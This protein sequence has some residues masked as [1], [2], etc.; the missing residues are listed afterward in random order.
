MTPRRWMVVLLLF[1]ALMLGWRL[2]QVAS[3]ASACRVV[4]CR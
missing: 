3:M 2:W 1:C 4:D